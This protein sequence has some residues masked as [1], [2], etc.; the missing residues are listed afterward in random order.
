MC[1]RDESWKVAVRSRSRVRSAG[2]IKHLLCTA[3]GLAAHTPILETGT[4]RAWCSAERA[5]F[6][7]L[8]A[9]GAITATDAMMNGAV[10]HAYALL[11]AAGHHSM[12]RAA[13]VC[14]PT[15]PSNG[16]AFKDLTTQTVPQGTTAACARR[17]RPQ[18]PI[19]ADWP[20]STGRQTPVMKRAS[21]EARKRAALATSQALPIWPPSGTAALRWAMSAA[22][23]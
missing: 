18:P 3:G 17:L 10:D 13:S 11:R 8:A 4:A 14:S 7:G 12:P 2:S 22:R 5:V 16:L 1:L 19:R 21:S 6:T 9:S 20:P 15:R 23:S